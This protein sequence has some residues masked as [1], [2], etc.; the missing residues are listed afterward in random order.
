[1]NSEKRYTRRLYFFR[2]RT[3]TPKGLRTIVQTKQRASPRKTRGFVLRGANMR[4]LT[5]TG[6]FA[7]TWLIVGT[8]LAYHPTDRNMRGV[9]EPEQR[10]RID[11]EDVQRG[12]FST[13]PARAPRQSA[14]PPRR[15]SD[16]VPPYATGHHTR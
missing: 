9:L 12:T 3:V 6:I 11:F 13:P 15:G 2:P 16:A 14:Q 10:E 7:G 1:M 4:I 8:A 5:F